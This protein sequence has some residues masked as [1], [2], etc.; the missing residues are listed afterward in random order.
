MK[1]ILSLQAIQEQEAGQIWYMNH[2]LMTPDL[3]DQKSETLTSFYNQQIFTRNKK[4]LLSQKRF[5]ETRFSR[6]V[7]NSHLLV[8]YIH[9]FTLRDNLYILP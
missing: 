9:A 3:H 4:N 5:H 8:Y 2:S 6:K 7:Q 1:T